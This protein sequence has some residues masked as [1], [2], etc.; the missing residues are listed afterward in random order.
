VRQ[1]QLLS[2][3]TFGFTLLYLVLFSLS[4]AL[5][6]G[7]VYWAAAAYMVE[8]T[9]AA[10]E[11]EI[12]GLAEGYDRGG[13]T[14]LR[15]LV[16]DRI[17]QQQPTGTSLYLLTDFAMRPIV[18]NLNRWPP[19]ARQ[20]GRWLE[21]DLADPRRP[22]QETH[23]ALAQAFRLTGGYR[24]LVGKD[25]FE[26]RQAQAGMFRTMAWGL[27]LTLL[28]GLAVGIFMSRRMLGR[29]DAI[30]R[31][32]RE[33]MTGD[34]GRRVPTTGSNDEF[35]RLAAN[36]NEM[37]DQI[38]SL[39]DSV[40]RVSD[41]IAHDLRTPLARL[42]NHLEQARVDAGDRLRDNLEAAV[43]DADQLLA[44][45][46]ALLRIVRIEYTDRS[47]FPLIDL[48]ALVRDV[49][50]LYDPVAEDRGVNLDTG[51]PPTAPSIA[52]DRDMLFQAVANLVDN[53]LKYTPAGGSIRVS[54][55]LDDGRPALV[56][57]DTGPGIP[58]DERERVFQ[59]FYRLE[60]SRT[61]PGNGLGLCLVAAVARV[62]GASVRLE[63]NGPG[64]RAVLRFHG[65]TGR[66]DNVHEPRRTAN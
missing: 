54:V 31:T 14:D 34:L 37:L 29:L 66:A 12:Q 35:D 2:S 40:R 32:S 20:T 15:Q 3:T 36:L 16:R 50:E 55:T 49:V 33:I 22:Q 7:F 28:L 9:E 52:A 64:L 25:L 60:S 39:L 23:P 61:S 51:L 42:R 17:S 53:A 26:L 62:H 58:E 21:F 45:F 19:D 27:A 1:R 18:G 63:D 57:E 5:L 59:R 48:N 46:N 47:S 24:L 65:E 10:I 11:S 43:R 6:F 38:E 56:V 8:Q 4:V 41:N 30:N 44:T 13:L